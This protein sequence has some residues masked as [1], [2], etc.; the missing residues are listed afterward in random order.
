MLHQMTLADD[1]HVVDPHEAMPVVEM[2]IKRSIDAM[3]ENERHGPNPAMAHLDKLGNVIS[4]Y[5]TEQGQYT[6]EIV[7]IE[8]EAG[9]GFAVALRLLRRHLN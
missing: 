2:L 5:N 6:A 3:E 7:S 1:E 4:A 8:V 9:D